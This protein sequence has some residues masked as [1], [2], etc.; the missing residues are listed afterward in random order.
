MAAR[1]EPLVGKQKNDATVVTFFRELGIDL[2]SITADNELNRL[3]VP[4]R[5]YSLSFR[6]PKG[7]TSPRVFDAVRFH[8]AKNRFW[9]Y[10]LGRDVSFAEYPS[11]LPRGITFTS[12]RAELVALLG[13]PTKDDDGDL[14]WKNPRTK[15]TLGVDFASEWDKIPKGEMK[16]VWLAVL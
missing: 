16:S 12:T 15:V 3:F 1:V 7:T 4:D 6:V 13:K 9:S 14:Q 5:G 10:V 8:R 2:P 11:A